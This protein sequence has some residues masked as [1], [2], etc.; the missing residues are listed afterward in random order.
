MD[1]PG[2]STERVPPQGSAAHADL[3][4]RALQALDGGDSAGAIDICERLLT[5]E[6]MDHFPLPVTLS[7]S[8]AP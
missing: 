5:A 6:G 4:S 3:I 8:S 1:S 7:V 2:E